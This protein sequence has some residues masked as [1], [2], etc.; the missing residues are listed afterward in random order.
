MTGRRRW[1]SG[2]KK[3]NIFI[4]NL[5][6]ESVPYPLGQ[7]SLKANFPFLENLN[8]SDYQINRPGVVELVDFY[9][10]ELPLTPTYR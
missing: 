8:E 2:T 10:L 3:W 6:E 7:K 1:G 9:H 4:F 5:E